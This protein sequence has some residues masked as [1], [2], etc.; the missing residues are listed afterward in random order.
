MKGTRPPVHSGCCAAPHLG[1]PLAHVLPPAPPPTHNVNTSSGAFSLMSCQHIHFIIGGG[2]R[3]REEGG[4][5]GERE[6]RERRER[7]ER[8]RAEEG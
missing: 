6:E 7:E 8:E 3:R 5:R 1:L 2:G 4:E